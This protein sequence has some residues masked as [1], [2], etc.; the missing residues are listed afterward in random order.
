ML[1]GILSFFCFRSS[2]DSVVFLFGL[3]SLLLSVLNVMFLFFF[4]FLMIVLI[5]SCVNFRLVFCFVVTIILFSIDNSSLCLT[6]QPLNVVRLQVSFLLGVVPIIAAWIYSEFLEYKKN[7][8][9][10]K[11]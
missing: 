11:A 7:C 9:C 5:D 1:Y 4:L 3:L 2:L 8:N 10:S 6:H